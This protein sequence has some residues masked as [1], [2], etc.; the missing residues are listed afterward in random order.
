MSEQTRTA[1]LRYLYGGKS[2]SI[3]HQEALVEYVTGLEAVASAVRDGKPMDAELLVSALDG[4][5]S[6]AAEQITDHYSRRT[7][8]AREEHR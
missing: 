4:D 1:A 5:R 2:M 3:Q 8:R 6:P 7:T